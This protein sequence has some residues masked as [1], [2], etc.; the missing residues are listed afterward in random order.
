MGMDNVKPVAASSSRTAWAVVILLNAAIVLALLGYSQ[1]GGGWQ[2]IPFLRSVLPG[3]GGDQAVA[4]GKRS[5]TVKLPEVVVG[6]RGRD[7]ELLYVDAAFDLEVASERD[8]DA[9]SKQMPRVRET[10]IVFLA[11]LSPD[12][13][14]GSGELARTK[15]RL[16]ERFRDAL[17]RQSLKALYVTYLAIAGSN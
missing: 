4:E 5:P 7:E 1:D 17:P 6:L 16:L 12:Q 9:V 2:N 13:L 10:T 11:D 15:G 8:R 3:G 14:R